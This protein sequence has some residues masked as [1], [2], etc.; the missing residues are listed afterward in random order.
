MEN[1]DGRVE[2]KCDS[3]YYLSIHTLDVYVGS[4]GKP[5]GRGGQRGIGGDGGKRGTCILEVEAKDGNN[6]RNGLSGSDGRNGIEGWDIALAN[7][8]WGSRDEFGKSHNVKLEVKECSSDDEDAICVKE[9]STEK[10]FKVI[11]RPC[12]RTSLT[13]YQKE[14][15]QKIES[16]RSGKAIAIESETIDIEAVNANYQQQVAAENAVVEE[17]CEVAAE[18][19]VNRILE[20]WTFDE[21]EEY[22][23]K[24]QNNT[25]LYPEEKLS[26][27][28]FL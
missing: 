6:G 9:G 5:G 16:E 28:I 18:E 1:D 21:R 17:E 3:S 15:Q 2:I 14:S 4:D 27:N 10:Y 8:T 23:P 20:H 25:I 26:S 7:K 12:A 19:E 24:R 11:P 13:E 22:I